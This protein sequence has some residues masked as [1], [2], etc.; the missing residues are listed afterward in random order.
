MMRRFILLAL[1]C[2]ATS[3]LADETDDLI[4][5]ISIHETQIRVVPAAEAQK[6]PPPADDPVNVPV[7]L[8][9]EDNRHAYVEPF[10]GRPVYPTI[11]AGFDT[12]FVR[13]TF[14]PDNTTAPRGNMALASRLSLNLY[15]LDLR[16]PMSTSGADQPAE[17]ALKIPFGSGAHRFAPTVAIHMP[18]GGGFTRAI[19]EAGVGYQGAFGKLSLKLEVSAF[20]GTFE[21]TEGTHAGGVFGWGGSIAY[22]VTERVA[23]IVEAEGLTAISER[24]G[25]TQPQ[26][27]DTVLRL[28]PG[29]R[30][31]PQADSRFY[32]GAAAVLSFVPA[33][34]ELLRRRG[35]MLEVGYTFL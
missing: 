13:E 30:W 4:D 31:F 9:E 8:R 22:L 7:L 35:A 1:L 17:L 2:S 11:S 19:Y 20:N 25:V 12:A 27:G 33:E 10:V 21:R 34:Y 6:T 32:V 5:A 28:Y 14:E 23:A 26:I 15:F 18:V 16:F 24:E 3:A 29:L